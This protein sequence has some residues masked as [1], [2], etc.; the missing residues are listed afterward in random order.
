MASETFKLLLDNS[1]F[2]QAYEEAT[3]ASKKFSQHLAESL[4]EP[5]NLTVKLFRDQEKLEASL[6]S[7]AAAAEREGKRFEVAM[8]KAL[9]SVTA[10]WTDVIHLLES[11]SG[12]ASA[13]FRHMEESLGRFK[14]STAEAAAASGPVAKFVSIVERLTGAAAG[15]SV[16]VNGLGGA[17]GHLAAP[18]LGTMSILD[19]FLGRL[20]SISGF[21]FSILTPAGL[22]AR[23]YG[24]T[25]GADQDAATLANQRRVT[26]PNASMAVARGLQQ[27]ANAAAV[28]T[29]ASQA[30]ARRRDA[31]AAGAG[32]SGG[33]SGGPL[34]PGMEFSA[35]E[36]NSLEK[37]GIPNQSA[38]EAAAER[39]RELTDVR[40]NA[41]REAQEDAANYQQTLAKRMTAEM[42]ADRKTV[43]SAKQRT[44]MM[45]EEGRKEKEIQQA[46]TDAVVDTSLAIVN[47]AGQAAEQFGA[48]AAA[49]HLIEATSEG[50]QLAIAVAKAANPFGGQAHY[51]EVVAHGAALALALAGAANPSSP[52]GG[53]GGGGGSGGPRGAIGVPAAPS[54]GGSGGGDT[55]IMNF[56]GLKTSREIDEIV[57]GAIKRNGGRGRKIRRGDVEG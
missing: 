31:A 6:K 7:A 15:G 55:I 9:A 17:I 34:D 24:R 13:S 52:S 47:A 29:G 48:G 35:D 26:D 12:S 14:A 16:V 32:G 3:R 46:R 21:D 18:I 36:A 38:V 37:Y 53:G 50:I 30:W 33:G 25:L 28:T 2:V 4:R 56:R 49:M 27:G 5:D 23:I 42:D 57:D 39:M 22:I 20:R 10:Y 51:A 1:K 45:A 19:D 11:G 8:K 43:L 44:A 40:R 41:L 54:S